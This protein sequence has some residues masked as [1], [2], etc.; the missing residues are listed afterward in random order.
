[1]WNRIINNWDWFRV[2]RL[3]IGV[4]VLIQ[5]IQMNDKWLMLFATLFTLMPILNM[6]CCGVSNCASQPQTM[7]NGKEEEIEYEEIK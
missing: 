3:A 2:L 7:P 5:S 4:M 1:M 6:G